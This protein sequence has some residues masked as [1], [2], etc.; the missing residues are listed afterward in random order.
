MYS[1]LHLEQQFFHTTRN[2]HFNSTYYSTFSS[3]VGMPFPLN[4][5]PKVPKLYSSGGI[6]IAKSIEGGSMKLTIL[7]DHMHNYVCSHE[8]IFV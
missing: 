5:A 7:V 4:G 3:L 2:R 8:C 1:A 6:N